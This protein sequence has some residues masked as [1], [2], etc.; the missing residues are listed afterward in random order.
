MVFPQIPSMAEIGTSITLVT[1]GA[2]EAASS[3]VQQFIAN[4][5]V[6]Q[7]GLQ[8]L[9]A[10]IEVLEHLVTKLRAVALG[11]SDVRTLLEAT[12]QLEWH[13]PA[14]TAFRTAVR[15]RQDHADYLMQSAHETVALARQGIEELQVRIAGLQSL[16]AAARAALG[17]TAAATMGQ[18]CS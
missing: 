2:C 12:A 18:V 6:A 13:S 9:A 11:I 3:A 8:A 7:V 5:T 1:H 16:L 4:P 15:Q 10:Q 14:G 17:D